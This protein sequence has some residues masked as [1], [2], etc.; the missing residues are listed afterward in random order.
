MGRVCCFLNRWSL[1]AALSSPT[2][3][4]PG[5]S[6]RGPSN[7]HTP[8]PTR[9]PSSSRLPY[10]AYSSPP[11]KRQPLNSLRARAR[12]LDATLHLT[13]LRGAGLPP[14]AQES[15][16]SSFPPEEERSCPRDRTL[17]SMR[18]LSRKVRPISGHPARRMRTA[19]L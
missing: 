3:R 11:R 13:L 2:E 12:H 14:G 15:G 16:K 6:G 19:S 5:L 17:E 18:L 4:L 9:V 10:R 7:K 1:Q 8:P